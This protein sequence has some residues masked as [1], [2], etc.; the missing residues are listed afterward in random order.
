MA[1]LS[2]P[3]ACFR[4]PAPDTIATI[5]KAV[6]CVRGCAHAADYNAPE[7]LLDLDNLYTYTAKA[8][9]YSFGVVACCLLE[10]TNAKDEF[11]ANHKDTITALSAIKHYEPTEGTPPSPHNGRLDLERLREKGPLLASAIENCWKK[12]SDRPDMRMVVEEFKEG[13]KEAS[14]RDALFAFNQTYVPP[15]PTYDWPTQACHVQLRLVI[16]HSEELAKLVNDLKFDGITTTAEC[17]TFVEEGLVL[18]ASQVLL[19]VPPGSD[20]DLELLDALHSCLV[21]TLEDIRHDRPH[22][23]EMFGLW[24]KTYTSNF[25]TAGGKHSP[26]F[27]VHATAL[28]EFIRDVVVPRAKAKDPVY[29]FTSPKLEVFPINDP[30][31]MLDKQSG[32]RVLEAEKGGIKHTECCGLFGGELVTE[33]E[34]NDEYGEMSHAAFA[35]KMR[36][37]HAR[38]LC[39]SVRRPAPPTHTPCPP[40]T[41][42]PL[43]MLTSHFFRDCY[44]LHAAPM[45]LWHAA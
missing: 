35:Q 6:A 31:S 5:T 32:L 42:P 20:N 25:Q 9:V 7:A 39:R 12:E 30:H 1:A 36:C 34:F 13:V 19:P 44:C 10:L 16:E 40:T 17:K 15:V 23:F 24:L 3:A 14:D 33:K 41:P 22:P 4:L 26:D 18:A 37:P 43:P 27:G 2:W 21:K 11:A 29:D 45:A 8:D 28:R 38:T